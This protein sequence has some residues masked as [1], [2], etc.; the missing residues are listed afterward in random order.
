MPLTFFKKITII[1][2]KVSNK[3]NFNP[4]KNRENTLFSKGCL[5]IARFDIYVIIKKKGLGMQKKKTI[6]NSTIY[7]VLLLLIFSISS[8]SAY[9]IWLNTNQKRILVIKDVETASVRQEHNSTHNDVP[10]AYGKD[11]G[12]IAFS[13][14]GS[15]YGI[16]MTWGSKSAL[17]SINLENGTVTPQN[18]LFPFEWGN[19]LTFDMTS[20]TGYAGGGL[21]SSSPYTYLKYFRSFFNHD[22]GTSQ[23]WYDMSTDY[24]N[25]GSAG[26]F[27]FA[28]GS[29]YAIW[30]VSNGGQWE[31]Y[32]LQF[33]KNGNSYQN[34]GRVDTAIG[35]SEGIWGL[36]SDG[37]T[38][39]ATSPSALYRVDIAAH[40][41]NYTK[42][43]DFTLNAN[44]KVNGATS[45]WSDLSLTH[46]TDTPAPDLNSTMTLTTTIQNSGPYDADSIVVKLS[47]PAGYEYLQHTLDTGTYDPH[48]SEWHIDH[49]PE[50]GSVSLDIT[51]KV[52]Q[53]GTMES[54]AEIIHA[55]QGDPDSHPG[56]SFSIDDM[57]DTLPDDDEA[58]ERITLSPAM[59]IEKKVDKSILHTPDTLSYTITLHNRGNIALS[60]IRLTDH[61]P[62]G[63]DILLFAPT[64]DKDGDNRLDTDEIWQYQAAYTVTQTEIDQGADIVNRVSARCNELPTALEDEAKTAVTQ[65]AAMTLNKEVNL[66]TISVPTVI[67]Y[68]FDLNNTGNISLHN[69]I[70]RNTLPDGSMATPLLQSGDDNHNGILDVGEVWHYFITYSITQEQIDKGNILINHITARSDQTGPVEDNISTV[71]KW[72]LPLAQD[73]T[74]VVPGYGPISGNLDNN[75]KRGSCTPSLAEWSIIDQPAHGTVTITKDGSYRYVPDTDYAG[76]DTFSYRIVF[77]NRCQS[78]NTATVS[79]NVCATTQASDSGSAGNSTAFIL[80][81]AGYLLTG[82]YMFG[83]KRSMQRS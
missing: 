43:T 13:Q 22:P 32:L 1:R 64:G 37:E 70:L 18:S 36:A 41:A 71:I 82:M 20:G 35:N 79:I 46:K 5:N 75:D 53:V 48:T 15:L 10:D 47:L 76:I 31:Y 56:S 63:R 26:D 42:I 51:V 12:D 77:P 8:L 34:L 30:L 4:Y 40:S 58:V 28:N 39:Y 17:Y 78:S 45:Q 52:L 33:T 65:S 23:I 3:R 21:E 74:L 80:F 50:S 6:L 61:L 14:D 16:S 7:A 62:D 59:S 49:L 66:T 67:G 68:S 27:A 29:L 9:D 38:L 81:L 11:F 60:G 69:V 44:E 55:A 19:A 2:Y 25:G 57:N 72:L 73:D 54:R 83:R 24:P